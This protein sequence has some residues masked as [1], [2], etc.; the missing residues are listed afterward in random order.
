M[1]LEQQKM[2]QYLA[3]KEDNHFAMNQ[4]EMQK[5]KEGLA[6][7]ASQYHASSQLEAQKISQFLASKADGHFS[8]NQLELHKVKEGIVA[9]AAQHFASNQLEQQ[10]IREHLSTQLADAK[11]EQLKSQQFLA[12]KLCECCCSIKEKVDTVKE[13]SDLIDRDRLRDNLSVSRDQA[14]MLKLNEYN[15]LYWNQNRGWGNNSHFGGRDGYDGYG[16][17]GNVYNNFDERRNRS[18]RRSRSRSPRRRDDD[19]H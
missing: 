6:C 14:N 4:L 1:M 11:Y 5:V 10:K 16:G 8:M 9:Q 12:D 18:P 19:H 2:G 15:Q 7:Q 13:H 17:Y 3:S